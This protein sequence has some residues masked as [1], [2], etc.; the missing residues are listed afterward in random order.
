[1]QSSGICRE[2]ADAMDL[3]HEALGCL[4]LK[5]R[6]RGCRNRGRDISLFRGVLDLAG[7]ELQILTSPGPI[8]RVI[9]FERLSR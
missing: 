5:S 9:A 6:M 4:T 8:Q 1:M 2:N 3:A 7:G